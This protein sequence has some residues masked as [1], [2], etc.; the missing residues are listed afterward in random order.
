MPLNK[1]TFTTQHLYYSTIIP[2]DPIGGYLPLFVG[3]TELQK[4]FPTYVILYQ[5]NRQPD[6]PQKQYHCYY[7]IGRMVC[8]CHQN[9]KLNHPEIHKR[10]HS[11]TN[12]YGKSFAFKS[13]SIL[14][15]IKDS[16]TFILMNLDSL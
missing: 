16:N 10:F 2:V 1:A 5:M 15:V 4:L 7:Y 6:E 12:F 13:L 8:V 3:Q 9:C 14:S 11:A